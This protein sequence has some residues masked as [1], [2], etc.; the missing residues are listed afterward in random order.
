MS[1]AT[2]TGSGSCPVCPNRL[3]FFRG[4]RD[5]QAI[6]L[7]IKEISVF[8]PA[9]NDGKTIGKLVLDAISVLDPLGLDYEIII[10]DDCSQDETGEVAGKLSGGNPRVK[11]VRHEENRDYGGVLKSGFAHA[12]K[13][14]V[15]YTDGDGQYDIKEMM[16]LLPYAGEYD[17]INGYI[18]KRQD[19]FYR[20]LVSKMYQLFLN[21]L[22]GKT[23]TYINCDFRLIRKE[24]IDRIQIRSSSGFA[25][26]EMV[27]RLVKSGAKVKE[28]LVSHFPRRYGR[29]QFLNPKKMFHILRDMATSLVRK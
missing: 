19:A 16:R 27:I 8:L 21:T 3:S 20:I 6:G 10:I 7:M 26:A 18:L 5:R 2:G 22:F 12:T 4:E 23:L 9:Y 17:L 15:F 13:S 29:S 1:N 28:V 24:A 25:P 11:W 14:W